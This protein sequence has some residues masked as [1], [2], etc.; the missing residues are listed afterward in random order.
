MQQK[1]LHTPDALGL[2]VLGGAVGASIRWGLIEVLPI[3]EPFWGLLVVNGLG[4]LLVGWFRGTGPDPGP[5]PTPLI[6]G[7]CGGLTTFSTVAVE[8]ALLLDHGRAGLMAVYL[9]ASLL[10][11][12]GLIVV[13]QRMRSATS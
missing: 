5:G 11:G 13:G 8:T 10:T 12:L 9:T 4:C 2:I 7:F 1:H 6:S 3:G